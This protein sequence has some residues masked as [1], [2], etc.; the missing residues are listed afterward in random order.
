MTIAV[1]IRVSTLDQNTDGQRA[2]ITRWLESHGHDLAKVKWFED[3]QTG[4]NLNRPE[5]K[6][7]A[8]AVTAGKIKTV[9]IWK[10]DRLARTAIDGMNVL[11]SWCKRGVRVVSITEQ[12][13]LSDEFGQLIANI[14][15]SLAQIE[16]KNAKE[17]QKAGIAAA[18]SKGRYKGRKTNTKKA[19]PSRAKELLSNGLKIPEI[20]LALGVSKRTIFNYIKK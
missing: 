11:A 17:R 14:M 1:Y 10:L 6:K 2:E 4:K 3:K 7:L 8:A 12:F 13:D 5:F 20:A 18:K 16:L 9:I 15:L 19:N